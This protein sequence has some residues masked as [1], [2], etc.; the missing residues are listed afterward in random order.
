MRPDVFPTCD[1][2][3]AV[4]APCDYRPVQVAA[5]KLAKNGRPTRTSARRDAGYRGHP[6]PPQKIAM[7]GGLRPGVRGPAIRAMQKL[8]RKKCDLIVVNGPAAMQSAD[9]KVEVIDARGEIL[10]AVAG[11]ER[12]VGQGHYSGSSKRS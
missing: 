5:G 8:E 10:A 12:Q 9:T 6:G 2:L 3:I 11:G 7:D 1:G 4:A